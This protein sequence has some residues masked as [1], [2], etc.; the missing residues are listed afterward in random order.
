MCC[1]RKT[2][3]NKEMEEQIKR[4]EEKPQGK[5]T[6]IFPLQNNN[7]VTIDP[8]TKRQLILQQQLARLPKTGT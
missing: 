2:I 3:T 5:V 7:S 4:S 8:E 6:K 1:G